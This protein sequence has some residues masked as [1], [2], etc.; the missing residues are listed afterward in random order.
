MN[1]TDSAYAEFNQLC[2]KRDLAAY[3]AIGAMAV[4]IAKLNLKESKQALDI[5]LGAQADFNQAATAVEQFRAA[6]YRKQQD[7]EITDGNRTA[8]A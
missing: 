6:Q 1:M 7:K 4:A 3:R 8:A 2:N 5:L